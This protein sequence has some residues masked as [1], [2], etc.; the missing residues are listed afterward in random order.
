[1]L[2]E[3]GLELFDKRLVSLRSSLPCSL[4][5]ESSWSLYDI[6]EF[7]S[8][9]YYIKGNIYTYT[10]NSIQFEKAILSFIKNIKARF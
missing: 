3:F 2:A 1:M 10:L 6:I 8:T 5:L 9:C 4:N 7:V